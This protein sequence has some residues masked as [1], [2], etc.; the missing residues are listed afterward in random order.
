MEYKGYLSKVA[1][2]GDELYGTVVNLHRDHV[3]FRVGVG[4][5]IADHP[6]HRSRRAGLPHRAPTSGM[7]P[8][9]RKG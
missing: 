3:D 8:R 7:T 1:V 5:S 2:D 9:R 4:M 6:L